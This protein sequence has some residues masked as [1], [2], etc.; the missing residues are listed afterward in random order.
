MLTILVDYCH[1][2]QLSR[3]LVKSHAKLKAWLFNFENV[4]LPLISPTDMLVSL[5]QPTSSSLP[6]REKWSGEVPLISWCSAPHDNWGHKEI[7]VIVKND[8]YCLPI[9]SMSHHN[10]NVWMSKPSGKS[11]HCDVGSHK[12]NVII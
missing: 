9:S 10:N 3:K 2:C 5:C 8:F 6:V 1:S 7:S 12:R 4:S 11:Y